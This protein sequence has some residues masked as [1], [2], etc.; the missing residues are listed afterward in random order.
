MVVNYSH[1]PRQ[2]FVWC[3]CSLS[4]FTHFCSPAGSRTQPHRLKAYCLHQFATREYIARR[5]GLEPRTLVLETKMITISLSTYFG[6]PLFSISTTGNLIIFGSNRTPWVK[7]GDRTRDNLNHNQ[8]LYHWATITMFV[9]P[10]GIEP[11]PLDFQ[12]NVR[13]SYTKGPLYLHMPRESNPFHPRFWRPGAYH[14]A[15][16]YFLVPPP[17]VEPGPID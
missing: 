15:D 5:L 12:S 2:F 10:Q 17:G 14:Y 9:D 7:D 1:N 6:C 3:C 16:L 13:T 4:A 11:C 8:A